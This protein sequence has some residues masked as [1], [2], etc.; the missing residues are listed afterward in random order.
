MNKL[1][2]K[3]KWE[4]TKNH[5]LIF[6][7]A[8][9]DNVTLKGEIIAV[10]GNNL[11]LE[12]KGYNR[13]SLVSLRTWKLSGKW[14]VDKE[15]RICFS[16]KNNQTHRE[17]I[18]ENKWEIGENQQI[19]YRYIKYDLVTKKKIAQQ[20]EFRGAWKLFTGEKLVYL[21]EG[22]DN[23]SFEFKAQLESGTMYPQEGKIKFRL[24]SGIKKTNSRAQVICFYGEWKLGAKFGVNFEVDS[25]KGK[26]Q[27]FTFGAKARIAPNKELVL[28]LSDK[29]S[30][31]LGL[32]LALNS[33][34]LKRNEAKAFLRLKNL[35][36]K[37][38]AVEVGVKIPF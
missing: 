37:D 9:K 32:D 24:G 11:V 35:L 14:Y 26:P 33:S 36:E 1:S 34:F 13:W 8:Q 17:F 38:R 22:S 28:S 15:N 20:I 21:L 3:G 2:D 10:D 25:K 29:K 18:F 12:L 30:K 5:E 19:V 31:P 7:P 23:S 6:T 27:I 4:F 16:V